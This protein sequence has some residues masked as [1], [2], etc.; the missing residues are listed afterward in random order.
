MA[1]VRLPSAGVARLI[2]RYADDLISLVMAMRLTLIRAARTLAAS[3]ALPVGAMF[4]A[5][6]TNIVTAT[7]ATSA[8][9]VISVTNI[10]SHIAI[11]TVIVTASAPASHMGLPRTVGVVCRLPALHTVLVVIA[12]VIDAA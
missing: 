12:P 1:A 5:H 7:S 4:P 3:V 9:S 11:S 8:T 2:V 10:A 6:P